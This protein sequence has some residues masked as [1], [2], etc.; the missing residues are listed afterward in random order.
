MRPPSCRRHATPTQPVAAALQARLAGKSID[1]RRQHLKRLG[2]VI[3][4]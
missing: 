2:R 3:S 1:I 4:L